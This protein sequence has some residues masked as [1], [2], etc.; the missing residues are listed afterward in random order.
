MEFITID[1]LKQELGYRDLRSVQAWLRKRKIELFRIGKHFR[2]L[3]SEYELAKMQQPLKYLKEKYGEHNLPE[4]ISANM[5]FY[6]QHRNAIE[7]KNNKSEQFY[8]P[9]QT[10]QSFLNR[11]LLT[12][13]YNER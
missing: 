12:S 4:V 1:E 7:N 8:K 11:F 9:T 13:K 10:E 6:T 5:N 3:K 2:I